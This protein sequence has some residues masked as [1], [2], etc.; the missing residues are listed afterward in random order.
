M[1]LSPQLA[2]SIADDMKCSIHRDINIMDQSG[3][4][5]AS[6]NPARLRQCHEGAR[7]VIAQGLRVLEVRSDSQFPGAQQGV[8]LPIVIDGETVG[9][10]GITGAPEEV[11]LFGAV[12]QRMTE[13]L[14]ESGRRQEREE[15]LDRARSLFL[16]NWLFDQDPDYG[17]LE[18][19]GQLLGVD[20]GLSRVVALMR[21]LPGEE[22]GERPLE[23]QNNLF[24][25]SIQNQIGYHSQNFCA[26][27]H[28]RVIILLSGEDRERALATVRRVHA[29]IEDFYGVRLSSGVSTPSQAP[30][31]LRRCYMEARTAC[32]VAAQAPPPRVA[33]YSEVSLD[34]AVESIPQRIRRDLRQMVF[35]GC[36]AAEVAEF[37]ATLDSY[38]RNGGSI[39][40][41]AR[42]AFIHR[43]TF[44]Y[45]LARVRDRTG[46]NPRSPRD[47][48]LLYLAIRA[49]EA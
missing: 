30:A 20:L 37:T 48:F 42:E 6:T 27:I 12:I 33:C 36:T 35:S 5:I 23:M 13:I 19:R 25:R 43:N 8:N 31:D 2:Q 10:I 46:R 29:G 45:R 34:F 32:Q 28:N 22:R 44:Q 38:F 24:L 9:V 26:V 41:C 49:P 14:V 16:E 3:T 47:A 7:Q 18:L 17:E 1:F 40:A 39:D 15:L 11:S 21:L 4:I